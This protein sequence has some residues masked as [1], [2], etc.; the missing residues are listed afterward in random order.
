MRWL[1]F[2]LVLT[3]CTSTRRRAPGADD[4]RRAGQAIESRYW[5]LQNAQRHAPVRLVPL[6]IPECVEDGAQRVPT[7]IYLRYP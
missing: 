2:S 6:Q 4:A 1:L 3:G 5:E 7:T